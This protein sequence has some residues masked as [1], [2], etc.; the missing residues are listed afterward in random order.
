[1]IV[2]SY[3]FFG[4]HVRRRRTRR[5]IMVVYWLFIALVCFGFARHEIHHGAEEFGSMAAFVLL[6]NIGNVLGGVRAG[7]MIKPYSDVHWPPASPAPG[8]E[9]ELT[10]FG[11]GR[12]TGASRRGVL[13]E[14]EKNERNGVHFLAYTLARWFALLLFGI[15]AAFGWAHVAWFSQIGPLMVFLL[16][17]VLWSLPQSIIL[18]SEP[19]VE[20]VL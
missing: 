7:G 19:D 20:E 2:E 6:L 9:G 10:L 13:D 11:S 15:Y 18:W 4:L 12:R 5:A 1:M 8:D 3:R 16:T 14:R 17:L